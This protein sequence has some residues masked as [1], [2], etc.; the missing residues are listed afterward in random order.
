M[1]RLTYPGG[2][3]VACCIFGKEEAC[4]NKRLRSRL[5]PRQVP[6]G[7]LVALLGTTG[8]LW[9]EEFVTPKDP[10]RLDAGRFNAAVTP[11]G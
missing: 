11:T 6:G 4:L 5:D 2:R 7:A 10:L 1:S 9:R 8:R 3:D